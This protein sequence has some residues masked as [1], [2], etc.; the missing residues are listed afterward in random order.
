MRKAE[1]GE[2]AE[3]LII[4]II[5][6]AGKGSRAGSQGGPKQYR[7]IGD[8]AVLSH[9]CG[10][11]LD[12][13]SI[14]K[15][16]CIIHGDD[17]DAYEA[18]SLSHEKL[19]SPVAGGETRQL[20][21]LAG[22]EA[23]EE[24][25]PSIVL[26]HD[27][28]RPLVSKTVIDAVLSGVSSEHG[29]LPCIAVSDTLKSADSMM[30]VDKTVPRSGLFAAQTPQGFSFDGLIKAHRDAHAK[31]QIEFTDDSALAEWAGIAVKIVP[32]DPTNVKL[33]TA[34]DIAKADRE[35]NQS[36]QLPDVRVGHGYD[37]HRLVPGDH[38]WLCGIKLDH[39]LKLDGHSDADVGLHALTDAVLATIGSGDIGSHFPPSDDRWKDAASH[40]FLRHA[41]DE[42]SKSGG[43][44]T[45]VDITL[46][47]ESPKIGPHRPQMRSVI[48]QICG[49]AVDRVSVKATT[50][51]TIG[52]VG[53]EEG[54]VAMATATVV[55]AS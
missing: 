43:R 36:I 17:R 13:E 41:I 46:V 24:W 47:C 21:V 30:M 38:V 55:F 35:M 7:K 53:R 49:I 16:I 22:L 5:V 33:T 2:E 44:L 12:H 39:H 4:A 28:A 23:I 45:H 54:I 50:N 1:Y 19:L 52:F 31:G 27:A 18:L 15:V 51:E 40:Q 6:A 34:E 8:A 37:T 9:T 48:G 3:P 29:A 14:D 42:V 10:A 25:A 20:S 26:V 11:F 32:G